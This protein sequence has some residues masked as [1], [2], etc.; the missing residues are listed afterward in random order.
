MLTNVLPTVS[1]IRWAACPFPPDNAIMALAEDYLSRRQYGLR[2]RNLETGNW[3]PEMLDN[4]SPDFVWGNDSET[5]YYVK[6]HAST[7]LPYQSGVIRWGLIPPTMSLCMK[8]KTRRS[9]SACI[10]PRLA[11]T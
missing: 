10:K 1:F 11:T 6:K 3:Y 2:F 9:T 7:L 4:V 8:K 5:V